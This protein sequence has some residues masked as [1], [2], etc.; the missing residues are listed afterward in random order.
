[1]KSSRNRSQLLFQSELLY[2]K[3]SFLRSEN[4]LKESRIICGT[5]RY[6][7]LCE[8]YVES[9]VEAQGGGDGGD[10]LSDETVEVGVG[11]S[12]DVEVATADVVD[13]LV[14]HHEGA[15]RVLQGR[16]RGQ[17]RVVRLHHR[18]RH[19]QRKQCHS[20]KRG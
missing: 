2:R 12:L 15:V 7:E 14:V 9:A 13:R 8:I 16:V 10:D 5:G 19:L 3:S 17:D 6:L 20:K 11:G 18:C 1:M 4:R